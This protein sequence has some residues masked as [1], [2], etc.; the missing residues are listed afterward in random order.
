MHTLVH[1][2]VHTSLYTVADSV[3]ILAHA[4]SCTTALLQRYCLRACACACI[5]H[6]RRSRQ[7]HWA[8]SL[9]PQTLCR[10]FVRCRHLRAISWL[11]PFFKAPYPAEAD[12]VG[13]HLM[14]G[15]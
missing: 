8:G 10:P 6:T 15:G 4:L 14:P 5:I 13:I 11:P 9:R 12:T 3:Y 7:A 2:E 1:S